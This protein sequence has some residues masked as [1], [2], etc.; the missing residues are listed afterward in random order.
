MTHATRKNLALFFVLISFGSL[1]CQTKASNYDMTTK[2][3]EGFLK[4]D[5]EEKQEKFTFNLKYGPQKKENQQNSGPQPWSPKSLS[6]KRLK[7]FSFF[8]ENPFD[9]AFQNHNKNQNNSPDSPKKFFKPNQVKILKRPD[10]RQVDLF[11]FG[12]TNGTECHDGFNFKYMKEAKRRFAQNIEQSTLI[13]GKQSSKFLN[14][15]WD[16][17]TE[18][19]T[20][21]KKYILVETYEENFLTK[22]YLGVLAVAKRYNDLF[23][24]TPLSKD[25]KAAKNNALIKL[26][27]CFFHNCKLGGVT[28]IAPK[29]D[30]FAEENLISLGFKEKKCD[31]DG[32]KKFVLPEEKIEKI[33][34][35]TKE[36][37]R[38]E[39]SPRSPG[40]HSPTWSHPSNPGQRKW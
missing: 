18:A 24:V 28:A 27:L 23:F 13:A 35:D 25:K 20:N 31:L 39:G 10:N 6:K 7:D 21:K 30:K 16:D 34:S 40:R 1:S 19:F 22:K 37:P 17:P 32:A 33:L 14:S 8:S 5:E 36:F 38:K 2:E 26:A 9:G 3:L 4:N 12:K 11:K 15:I 29:D